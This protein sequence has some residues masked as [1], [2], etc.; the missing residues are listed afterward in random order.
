M[1]TVWD[2]LIFSSI[3]A[4]SLGLTGGRGA[5]G[6]WDIWNVILR[7]HMFHFPLFIWVCM[8][9]LL[10]LSV[11][12]RGSLVGGWVS[13]HS[14]ILEVIQ[15]SKAQAKFWN[16]VTKQK[17]DWLCPKMISW[18]CKLGTEALKVWFIAVGPLWGTDSDWLSVTQKQFTHEYWIGRWGY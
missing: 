10:P 11:A 9:N 1:I 18:D 6:W 12:G 2:K 16:I 14:Y 7:L 13:V 17:T 15:F 5:G 3:K 8:P 4:L